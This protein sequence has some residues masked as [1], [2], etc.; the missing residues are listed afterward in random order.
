MELLRA[1][2]T[3]VEAPTAAHRAIVNAVGI[4]I[5]PS[6]DDHTEVVV[7][8]AYPYAS[9]YL[10]AE[11]MMG[12]DARDRIA[13]FWRT[14]GAEPGAE[15]DHLV[16]LFGGVAA[17]ADATA[18]A[19]TPRAAAGL[20]AARHA[21]FW[22]HVA[23]WMPPYLSLLRRVG[24]DFYGAWAEL[25][26]ATLAAEADELGGPNAPS[27]H[28][29]A[30]PSLVEPGGLDELI[31]WLLAPIRMGFTIARDDLV[32]AADELGTGCRVGERRYVL[33]SLFAHD[34]PGM[35][36]W[37]A[38]EARRQAAE[39]ERVVLPPVAAWWAARARATAD[40]L[41]GWATPIDVGVEAACG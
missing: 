2:A 23:S 35:L 17:L 11:G 22:E 38:A 21:L 10:G 40:V 9:V 19:T 32:R 25:A 33:R 37:L 14:L 7:F 31:G 39:L 18:R 3:L 36:L 28:L 27:A 4:P 30:A 24:G 16:A 6:V 12:G 8:Q 41:Q 13:G 20:H 1:L 5:A 15:P 29:R 26:E 34:A